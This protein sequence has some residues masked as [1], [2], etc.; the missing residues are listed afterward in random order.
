MRR[1]LAL[2]S[3]ALLTAG[4]ALATSASGAMG[5]TAGVVDAQPNAVS[6]GNVAASAPQTIT[7]TLTDTGTSTVNISSTSLSGPEQGDFSLSNNSCK[8]AADG[9]NNTCSVDVT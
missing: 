2:A 1:R 4:V 6:F 3:T 8:G 7:E 5:L 9:P